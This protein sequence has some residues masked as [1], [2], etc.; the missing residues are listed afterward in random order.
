MSRSVA[1]ASRIWANTRPNLS[2]V[3][4]IGCLRGANFGW[5]R[6]T[7]EANERH[8]V[9][10]TVREPKRWEQGYIQACETWCTQRNTCW[11]AWS[12]SALQAGSEMR[13]SAGPPEAVARVGPARG[14]TL[15]M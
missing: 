6:K 5:V 8:G 14:K 15:N 9:G 13:P 1:R 7:H 10:K 11:R 2:R 12:G 4:A 3:F